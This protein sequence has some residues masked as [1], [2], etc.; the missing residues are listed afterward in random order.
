MEKERKSIRW[1]L[2]LIALA[3]ALRLAMAAFSGFDLGGI[4][5]EKTVAWLLYLETGRFP[6]PGPEQTAPADSAQP[7]TACAAPTPLLQPEDA[8]LVSVNN[9]TSLTPDVPALLLAA[10]FPS[11][12]GNG[13]TVLIVHTHA[14]ESYLAQAGYTESSPYRTHDPNHNMVSVGAALAELLRSR[15]IGVIHDTRLH[16]VPDYN[17]AYTNS[18]AAI[19]EYLAQYPSIRLVLDLHRDAGSDY[20]NQ[21]TTSA[22]VAGEASAQ[23]MLVVSTGHDN[24]QQN[25][26]CAVQL[27]AVLE[28]TWPGLCRDI[29]FRT[30]RF[31]QDLGPVT[32][33]VEVGAAGDTRQEALVAVEALADA[34]EA[35]SRQGLTADP[36][37]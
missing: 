22:T 3:A 14:S 1:G 29:N 4:S 17:S 16:D 8:R 25:M 31:N 28:K 24:W 26:S 21:L 35:L 5:A 9:D 7:T 32:L 13:P 33:L 15:G 20:V 11:L 6:R 36:T 30:G 18:R 37:R 10:E 12:A 34:I 27:Q 23:L 19:R 2:L